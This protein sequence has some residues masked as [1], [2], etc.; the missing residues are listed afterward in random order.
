MDLNHRANQRGP[1]NRK[2]TGGTDFDTEVVLD[3]L[4]IILRQLTVHLLRLALALAQGFVFLLFVVVRAIG[5]FIAHH[6]PIGLVLVRLRFLV[7]VVTFLRVLVR[8]GD[9][10]LGALG[11]GITVLALALFGF[12]ILLPSLP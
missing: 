11:A 10:P 6:K 2:H 8:V 7:V 5:L 1:L 12:L 9:Q 3:Q 4:Q